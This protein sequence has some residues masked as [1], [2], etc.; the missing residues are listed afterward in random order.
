[1]ANTNSFISGF[2][3]D[4]KVVELASVLAGP[5]AGM[6]FAELGAQVTK[7]ENKKNGGDVTRNWRIPGETNE[8]PSDYFS[9]INYGKDHLLLDL[10]EENDLDRCHQLITE[11]DLVISNYSENIAQKLRVDLAT[12]QKLNLSTVFIQL[13]GFFHS[14]RPAYDVVLQAETGWISMTGTEGE[15]AKMPVALIDILAGHQIKEAALLGIVHK[16]RTGKGSYFE[17]NLEQVS[18]SSLANQATNYLMNDNVAGP[19]GTKH[20]NIAPYGDWFETRDGIRFVLAIGSEKQFASFT[21]IIE[22]ETAENFSTNTD[23]LKNR[24]LLVEMISEKVRSW[25]FE[26]LADRMDQEKIPYGKIKSLDEVLRSQAAENMIRVEIQ[27][28]RETK[29]LSG[30]G[31]TGRSS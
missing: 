29:R 2:F 27:E 5:S 21:A 12:V 10:R 18:L 1:M 30:N 14:D 19:I 25:N 6:F 3:K 23:R 31:F 22:L 8:G 11:A 7:I 13:N 20:P 26:Y 15:P 17:I 4:L 28:G 16:L 9:S 24:N